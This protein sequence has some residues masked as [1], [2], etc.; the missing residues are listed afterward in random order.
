MA[1]WSSGM[2]VLRVREVPGSIPG[3]APCLVHWLVPVLLKSSTFLDSCS[4]MHVYHVG[5]SAPLTSPFPPV[6]Q[7]HTHAQ[8]AAVSETGVHG[9]SDMLREAARLPYRAAPYT[10]L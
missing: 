10:C 1:A 3:A 6:R 8:L 9:V 5:P 4:W 7:T 2:I